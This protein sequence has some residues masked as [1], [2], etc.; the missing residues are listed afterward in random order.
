MR[1]SAAEWVA[2]GQEFQMTFSTQV[3]KE[4]YIEFC[5]GLSG[6]N[7]QTAEGPVAGTG[8]DIQWRDDG[9]KTGGGPSKAGARFYRIRSP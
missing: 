2:S 9:S 1:I 3:G 6:R 5:G 4:Y 7:W 8:Q